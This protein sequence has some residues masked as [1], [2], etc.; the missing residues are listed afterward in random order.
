MVGQPQPTRQTLDPLSV[1]IIRR[2]RSYRGLRPI[3]RKDAE[4]FR[5]VLSGDFAIQGFRNKDLRERLGLGNPKD[6]VARHR[7]SGRITRHLR[8]L[9]AHG[10]IRK[11]SGTRYY[12]VTQKGHHAMTTA[13]RLREI[14]IEK[15]AA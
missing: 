13:L 2:G 9:R 7:A 1:R 12:R 10:L 4:V 5:V 14:D 15:L 3:G 11:I 8:L 6:P